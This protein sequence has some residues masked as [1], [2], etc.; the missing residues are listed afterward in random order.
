MHQVAG[1][2]GYPCP[3]QEKISPLRLLAVAIIGDAINDVRN[4]ARTNNGGKCSSRY[5]FERKAKAKAFIASPDFDVW[6]S[7]T[8]YSARKWREDARRAEQ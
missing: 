7:L 1:L 8:I 5:G 4:L 6:A 2:F 3:H